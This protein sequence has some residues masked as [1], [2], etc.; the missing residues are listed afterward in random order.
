[1][2]FFRYPGGKAKLSKPIIQ[3]IKE[4][5]KD[6]LI[7]RYM[8]PFFGGGSICFAALKENVFPDLQ[9]VVAN[10]TDFAIHCIWRTVYHEP[11]LLVD[12]I[13]DFVP[14]TE[15]FYTF[16]KELESCSYT[17]ESFDSIAFKKIALHQMSYSGLGVKAGGPIGGAK[18]N[19]KYD[20]GCRWSPDSMA[21]K[22]YKDHALLAPYNTYLFATDF[23][24]VIDTN[25]TQNTFIY[26]DPPYFDKGSDLYQ[27]SFSKDDHA[28]LANSLKKVDSHWLLSYDSC[29]E[30]KEMY[31]W[32][33]IEEVPVNYTI[34]TARAKSELFIS[35]KQ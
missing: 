20:I 31:D 21:K 23:E 18:Q 9:T 29:S 26:V 16:K 3:K 32:A 34:T 28:R 33:N 13:K 27:F 11:K 7:H 6:K 8:E 35:P 5:T 24:K 12:R 22:I 15:A 14:S 25:A 30:I 10:D 4:I 19:S 2:S 1:M 17:N